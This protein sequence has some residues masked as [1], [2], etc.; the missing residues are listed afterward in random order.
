VFPLRFETPGPVVGALA[1]LAV[2][3]LPDDEL[4][5]YRPAIEAVTIEAVLAAAGHI[6]TEQ[7][8]I[9]LVGDADAFGAELEAAGFGPVVV[10]RDT[11]P[12]VDGRATGVQG[13]LEPLDE[14]PTGPTEGA[15]TPQPV[16]TATAEASTADAPPTD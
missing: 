3:D 10:E 9:V 14:G 6:R 5:R 2:H 4:T 12:Q 11:V 7:A 1:G 16:E 8:A 13:D 15:E